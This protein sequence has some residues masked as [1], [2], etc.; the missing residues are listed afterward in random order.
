MSK[1]KTKQQTSTNFSN[2]DRE[3]HIAALR[4][5]LPRN[6]K[7]MFSD[8]EL[9]MLPSRAI[10]VLV[11]AAE[12][13]PFVP[14]LT[15]VALAATHSM[16]ET[17]LESLLYSIRRLLAELNS[18]GPI[19]TMDDLCDRS[20][21]E[22]LLAFEDD[23]HLRFTVLQRYA[24]IVNYHLPQY[25]AQLSPDAREQRTPYILP[26]LPIGVMDKLSNDRKTFIR[27]MQERRKSQSDALTP[28]YPILVAL[29]AYR[30]EAVRIICDGFRSARQLVR[31]GK[32]TL[33]YDFVVDGFSP[34]V[35]PDGESVGELKI[36]RRPIRWQF[37][38][39]NP[40]SWIAAGRVSRSEKTQMRYKRGWDIA[41]EYEGTYFVEYTGGEDKFLWIHEILANRL[42]QNFSERY[43]HDQ[44][45]D[46][47]QESSYT[48]RWMQAK[49]W[50]SKNGIVVS[51]PGLLSPSLRLGSWFSRLPWRREEIIFEPESLFRGVLYGVALAML[52]LTNGSRVHEL[53]QVSIEQFA[54]REIPP[55]ADQQNDGKPLRVVLQ[56]LLPKGAA[57]AADRQLYPISPLANTFLR[58][59][60]VE[61][62]LI[63]GSVPL[64]APS[65]HNPKSIMLK[66][67]HYLFQF[68]ASADR[69]QGVLLTKDVPILIRFVLDGLNLHT[70]DGQPVRIIPH[71]LRHVMATVAR[72]DYQV[73]PSVV[74]HV[75]HHGTHTIAQ[76]HG[77]SPITAHYA[78]ILPGTSKQAQDQDFTIIHKFHQQLE[79]D[80]AFLV[81][82]IPDIERIKTFDARTERM[83]RI[84]RALQPVPF[85]FCGNPEL[86]PRG[87]HHALC[88]D[89]RFL[90][91]DPR[92]LNNA[93]IWEEFFSHV[94]K[95]A[96][97]RGCLIDAQQARKQAQSL[98]VI[99]KTMRMF[100]DLWERHNVIPGIYRYET[101]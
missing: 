16:V 35:G 1:Q 74:A 40:I 47:Q 58:R 34:D 53:L 100:Q 17:T 20:L 32:A 39:W 55:R 85:G 60:A 24:S 70:T 4:A 90:L 71:I 65:V 92:C 64:V 37:R 7:N 80:A 44:I 59:I 78:G 42:L 46:D 36:E 45:K 49:L 5:H 22:D 68:A 15:I 28:L 57:T 72:H 101:R 9:A 82:D 87:E 14:H 61:L 26:P 93:V 84:W 18:I 27:Q 98:R 95:D 13:T 23:L 3:V 75:L 30:E 29:I 21:W 12:D 41:A 56:S 19:R 48:H 66:P 94:A 63:H 79:A 83:F 76:A 11:H 77:V 89:C 67:E 91:H 62:T 81:I 96:E 33:P 86:C 69:R 2:G 10:K 25:T 8:S 43:I 51:R 99:I 38:L 97:Q 73:P 54:I 31:D 6:V 52:A 88:L 50:G